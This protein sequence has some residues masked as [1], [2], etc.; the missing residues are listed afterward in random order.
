[1]ISLLDTPIE[2]HTINGKEFLVKRED[3]ACQS[4]GPPFSKVR[5]LVEHL[6]KLKRSGITTVGYVETSISMAGWGVAW[7]TKQ[8][9]MKSV[10]FDPQYSCDKYAGYLTHE[11]H[12]LKWIEHGAE[13]IKIYS[14]MAKVNYNICKRRLREEFSDSVMLPLG[15]PLEETVDQTAKQTIGLPEAASLVICV[16]SGTIAAGVLK[17]L[18]HSDVKVYGITCRETKDV[19]RKMSLIVNKAG[20]FQ[21]GIFA[22]KVKFELINPGYSYTWA[23]E[24]E[25]P[26]PCNKYY[27]TK[28]LAFLLEHYNRLEKPI[29]FWNIGGGVE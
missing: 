11:L 28:A 5:G 2:L 3:L 19:R 12:R 10:I 16:G 20:I 9:G 18:R 21:E 23:V 6:L 7:A 8:L 26:F 15:L 1:M 24:I 27:D 25:T 14:G 13:I 4:P 29:L 22:D 17:G